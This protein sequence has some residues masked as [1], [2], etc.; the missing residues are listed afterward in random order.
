VGAPPAR[1][2]EDAVIEGDVDSYRSWE[3]GE[4]SVLQCVAVGVLHWFVAVG[5]AVLQ[6][7]SVAVIEEDGDSYRSWMAG[8]Q[9]VLQCVAVG[10]LQWVC[11]SGCCSVAVLQCCCDRR[12]C[13]LV[14]FVE[15]G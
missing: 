1:K 7:C 13:R 4:Q 6:C 3:A 10:V 15:G 8:E 11:C 9:C 2:V 14:S 12:R 5:V